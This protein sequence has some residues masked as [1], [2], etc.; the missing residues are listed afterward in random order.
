MPFLRVSGADLP[1]PRPRV[2]HIDEVGSAFPDAQ[3]EGI[4]LVL[5]Q[6][7]YTLQKWI[8]V[9]DPDDRIIA[10]AE[11]LALSKG[12]PEARQGRGPWRQF[13]VLDLGV[14]VSGSG[15]AASK[16]NEEA[17][18]LTLEEQLARAYESPSSDD[19]LQL[20]RMAA[21]SAPGSAVALL[22]L[23]SA[24]REVANM[25]GAREALDEAARL[26]PD[27]EAV[28]YEDGKFWLAADAT[29][30]AREAFQRA[31]ELMPTFS[32]AQSNLGA[33]LGE[34]GRSEEAAAAFERALIRTPTASLFSTISASSRASSAASASRRRLFDGSSPSTPISSLVTT[35]LGIRSFWIVS[36]R[37]RSKHTRKATDETRRRTGARV[38][39][40]R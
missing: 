20:C 15:R 19:R 9:L 35:T 28:H 31:S 24:Y 22:A 7:G 16:G 29:D 21:A 33:T 6:P 36:I 26:A 13:R 27:W 2:I 5:T 3:A 17:P 39:G 32:A 18:Q 23:A 10:T 37:L 38:A 8:D 4:R 12:A 40:S 11:Q 14:S 34:L 1:V 25:E 30:Q